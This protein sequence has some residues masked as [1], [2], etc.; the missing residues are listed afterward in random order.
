MIRAGLAGIREGLAQPPLIAND[1]DT[2]PP[3]ERE[4]LGLRRLPET[5]PTALDAFMR[6]SIVQD[7]FH[8][9]IIQG[10]LAM[11]RAE[12]EMTSAWSDAEICRRYA[13]VY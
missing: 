9:E 6:D 8:P 12:I 4:R 5:L 2:L 7:W 1:P 10:F 3:S 13:E 11:K